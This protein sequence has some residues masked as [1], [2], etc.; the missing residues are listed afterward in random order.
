MDG[1]QDGSQETNNDRLEPMFRIRI[2]LVRIRIQ[3]FRLNNDPDPDTNWIHAGSRVLMTKNKNK[4]DSWK[5]I[6]NFF[7][8]LKLQFTY[9]QASIKDFQA[10]KEAFTLQKRTSNIENRE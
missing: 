5:K 9:S 6:M 4:N 8:D 3:N 10:T 2:H 7:L 1:S